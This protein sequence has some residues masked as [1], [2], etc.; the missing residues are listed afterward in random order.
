MTTQPGDAP[1][2]T[3]MW[4]YLRVTISAVL[5]MLMIALGFAVIV[6][7]AITKSV[8]LTVLTSSMEPGLPPGTLVIVRPV[9][10]A[11]IRMG[12]VVT[13]QIRSG[14]PG[15]ITHRIIA[16][17]TTESGERS[18]T[19]QGDN[20]GAPDPDAVREVQVQGRVW[21]S[22]PY[23]GW[24]NNAMGTDARDTVV[25]AAAG[26][27]LLYAAWTILSSVFGRKK[28]R[29]DADDQPRAG[30]VGAEPASLVVFYP[31]TIAAENGMSPVN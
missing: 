29:R 26:A 20:N 28:A 17:T 7:P 22:L 13:Y 30:V 8:P 18:F 1:K 19:L 31:S 3:S 14:E 5:L 12:D 2:E 25:P 23:L 4:G 10:P 16:I 15:V 24:V 9:A 27:L 6:V 21:Y 11:D